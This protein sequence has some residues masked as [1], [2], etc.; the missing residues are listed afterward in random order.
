MERML[1]RL[2]TRRHRATNE[3]VGDAVEAEAAEAASTCDSVISPSSTRNGKNC[4]SARN[5]FETGR[6][7]AARL[8]ELEHVGLDVFTP[9]LRGRDRYPPAVRKWT[10]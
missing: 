4:C 10:S 6:G 8:P 7:L 2:A 9:H 1:A 3:P 5:R